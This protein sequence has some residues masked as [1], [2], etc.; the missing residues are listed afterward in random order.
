LPAYYN[1]KPSK[2]YWLKE[3]W[4]KRYVDMSAE[5]LYEFGYGLSYTDFEYSNLEISPK[6]LGPQ[7]EIHVTAAVRNAG[8]RAGEE[9]AQ[10]Y[11]HDEVSSVTRPVKELKGFQKIALKPGE[12]RAVRFTLTPEHL[13]FLD[14][15]LHRAVEPGGFEVMLGSSS[16]NIRLTGR[17]EVR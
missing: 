8:A 17:F 6:V 3:G 14:R 9:I 7:G 4:G 12:T 5:P 2:A 10:L 16:K 11:L 15:D 13:S 1:Y